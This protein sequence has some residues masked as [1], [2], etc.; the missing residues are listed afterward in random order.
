MAITNFFIMMI[1][2]SKLITLFI[3]IAVPSCLTTIISLIVRLINIYEA[4]EAREY[5]NN[6]L[7]S[8]NHYFAREAKRIFRIS[9]PITILSLFL[10]IGLPS[11]KDIILLGSFKAI[12]SYNE[13]HKDSMLS[14][15]GAISTIDNVLSL[16]SV[17]SQKAEDF[18]SPKTEAKK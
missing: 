12:D 11:T 15:N 16:I 13:T 14:T 8:S 18:I 9:L 2:I 10:A 7:T 4:Y 5:D 1:A 6:D 3:V 17:A